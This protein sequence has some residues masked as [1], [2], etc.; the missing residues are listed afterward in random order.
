MRFCDTHV[1]LT[2][3]V[4]AEGVEACLAAASAA[5]ITALIQPGVGLADWDRM[6]ALAERHA[7]VY[8]AP[9]L[10]PCHADAW[11]DKA[12]QRLG[13]L[14]TH[15]KVVAVGEIGLDAAVAP[16]IEVQK[17]VLRAQLQIALDAGLPVILHCRHKNG[18]LFDILR[19]LDI[20]QR[21]GGVWHGFSASLA[22]A[23]QVVA[24]GFA[25]GV[26][27]VLL[28]NNVRKLP[29]AV[30]A[31]PA[32]ALVLETDYPDMTTDPAALRTVAAKVALLRDI[33]LERAAQITT[34]NARR[35]FPKLQDQNR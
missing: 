19:E 18:A 26:G 14:L 25:L 20:G 3:C 21:V 15:P 13:E 35:L 32:S 12:A 22:F 27:P 23:R 5:G 24:C 4:G 16:A 1:H 30:A 7:Q 29:D 2:G 6:R 9:G 28:R 17:R 31:L 11:D 34:G 33:S 8:L 10:H